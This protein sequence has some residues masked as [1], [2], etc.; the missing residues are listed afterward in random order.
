[1]T[2]PNG[3]DQIR[4]ERRILQ[5]ALDEVRTSTSQSRSGRSKV[6][7]C[8]AG[9][10]PAVGALTTKPAVGVESGQDRICSERRRTTDRVDDMV[11]PPDDVDAHFHF[12]RGQ[13]SSGDG[14]MIKDPTVQL[15]PCRS[16]PSNNMATI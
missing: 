14:P 4:V 12:P 6:G 8:D 16:S 3:D 1:M 15:D 11:M 13:S 10:L 2:G 7:S 9:R 5:S